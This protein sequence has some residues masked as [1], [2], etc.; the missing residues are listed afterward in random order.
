MLYSGTNLNDFDFH[1]GHWLMAAQISESIFSKL[2]Q[3]IWMKFGLLLQ[4]VSLLSLMLYIFCMV[5]IEGF[6]P[7]WY[8]LTL[9]IIVE[10]YHSR[11]KPSI[12]KGIELDEGDSM[13]YTLN[14]VLCLDAYELISFIPGISPFSFCC[15]CNKM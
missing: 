3:V 14:I 5:S 11:Q 13:K 4:P 8:I 12:Y 15:C 9:Y 6:G 7:E 2:F 1:S 10:I